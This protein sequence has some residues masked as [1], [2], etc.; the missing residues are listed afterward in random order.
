MKADECVSARACR[1]RSTP[2]VARV[3]H[4]ELR[5]RFGPVAASDVGAE[6][7][8]SAHFDSFETLKIERVQRALNVKI[9]RDK[10]IVVWLALVLTVVTKSSG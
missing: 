4:A 2:P 6:L 1:L 5:H 8:G 7:I 10:R 9:A 3:I